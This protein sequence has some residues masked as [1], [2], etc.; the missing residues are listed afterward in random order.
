MRY[1]IYFAKPVGSD[2]PIKIGRTRDPQKRL[3]SMNAD[4]PVEL[5]FAAVAEAEFEDE[6]KLHRQFD[7]CHLRGSWFAASPGITRAIALI[8]GGYSARAVIDNDSHADS[9]RSRVNRAIWATRSPSK[10]QRAEA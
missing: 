8:A 3:R 2:G 5:E 9:H 1:F 4:S 10:T 7:N 6:A